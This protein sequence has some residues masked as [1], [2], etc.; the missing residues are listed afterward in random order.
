MKRKIITID[1]DKCDGCGQCVTA[2]A[3][4][5]IELVDGKA[6]LVSEV[7]C[8]GLGACI[9]E[10]PTGALVIEE[11]EAEAF[12]EEAV[13]G[14]LE[15]LKALAPPA[16]CDGGAC[17]SSAMR[18]LSAHKAR[19]TDG[20]PQAESALSTWPVQLR[21]VPPFAP[22]LRGAHLLISADCVPFAVGDFHRRY[23][24]G[25][26]AL[27]GCP[28]LDDL[29]AYAEKIKAILR[30]AEPASVTVLRMEV[31]CCA[32][33]AMV[34]VDAAREVAPKVPLEVH[35]IG[36]GGKIDREVIMSEGQPT[37]SAG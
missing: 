28:K 3:E 11:R 34:T 9:G 10:C 14:R 19:A 22:F 37:G 5:A 35:T 23:L 4:G 16:G 7:Y 13:E 1:R 12:D 6:V 36:I 29:P 31:P 32:G 33:L 30:E 27:V 2:C 8:D 24:E 18:K 17:P 26:V 15:R 20:A 25:R 21:L